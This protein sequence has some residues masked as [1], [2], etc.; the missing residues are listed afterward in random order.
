MRLIFLVVIAASLVLGS[1]FR[2]SLETISFWLMIGGLCAALVLNQRGTPYRA[3][4]IGLIGISA[5]VALGA[6]FSPDGLRSIYFFVLPA[7]LMFTALLLRPIPYGAFSV[8]VLTIVAGV[9]LKEMQFVAHGGAVHRAPTT[10][11]K[12]LDMECLFFLSAMTGGL[13]AFD[14][15]NS[16]NQVRKTSRELTC[17]N[18]ALQSSLEAQQ[19]Q[20]SALSESEERFHSLSNLSLEGIMIHEGGAIVDA[21]LAF[22]RLFGYEHPEELI[23]KV[24]PDLL[25]SEESRVRVLQRIERRETGVVEVTGVRRDGHT[26]AAEVESR[27]VKYLGRDAIMVA[28]HDITERLRAAEELKATEENYRRLIEQADDGVF[29]ADSDGRF[30]VVNSAICR[31]LGYSREELCQLSIL[32]TYLPGDKA[33]GQKRIGEVRSGANARFER[34]M[35]R[36]DGTSLP[37]E[38][39]A[40][41]LEDGRHQAIARDIT[42]RKLA[43]EE[44]AK[45]Q[46]QLH[47][48][49]RMESIGRLAGGVAHDFNNLL[50]V[51]NGYSHLLLKD[52]KAGDPVRDGL[53]QICR[54]GERAAGLTQ[55]L[56]AFSRKQVLQPRALDLNRV[57]EEM[58]PMLARLVG[59][60][61]E[62]SVGLCAEATTIYADPHQLEQVIM[63]LAANAR[64]AM[65]EGGKLSIDTAVVEWD[66]SHAQ[67]HPQARPGPHV[68]L[69]VSDT[70]VGMDEETRRHIFEPFFTT[71]EVGQ[72]TGLGLS[73]I[74]GIVE[75]SGGFIEV[76]SQPACGTTLRVY[77]PRTEDAAPS[78]RTPEAAPRTD[79]KETVL[80]VEDQL[81]VQKYAAAAL[82]AHGYR[83]IQAASADEALPLWERESDRIDLVLTDVVMPNMS[84]PELVNQ[85]ERRRPGIKVLFMSGY[86]DDAIAHHGVLEEGVAFIQKPFSP[87]QLAGKVR[88]VLGSRASAGDAGRA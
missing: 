12:I 59:E 53:E 71:K 47:H 68:L 34:L 40:R 43:E 50:T 39:S 56:L 16:L 58:R 77:L 20:L 76:T 65:R 88:A 87:D 7:M 78:Q 38:I 36:K 35:L 27:P 10:Y 33:A 37:V 44:K 52:M 69:A 3:G 1:H 13:L 45:L 63:N 5:F 28:C 57:V 79:G 18:T 26:F 30:V 24:G 25:L 60:D 8:L 19:S 66:E 67:L 23:G 73:M 6:W 9:G 72:G 31:M 62:L 11:S 41:R 2:T 15:R 61:L 75:Q 21:N 82:R 29:V 86:S 17:A 84:G 46:A 22:A 74:Q 83:V 49:Q 51:I 4:P 55:Q 14:L 80:V 54:A 64:D 32:D 81:E 70:G 48:A 42:E 85:L